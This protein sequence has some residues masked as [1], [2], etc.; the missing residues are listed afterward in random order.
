MSDYDYPH[1]VTNSQSSTK[2]NQQSMILIAGFF[3]SELHSF[4]KPHSLLSAF[5]SLWVA[6]IKPVE[7]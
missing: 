5:A 3:S 4:V 7:R 6:T 2:K 1:Q